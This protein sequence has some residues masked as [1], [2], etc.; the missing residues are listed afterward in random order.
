MKSLLNDWWQ[1]FK[2]APIAYIGLVLIVI[3]NIFVL[4]GCG[5]QESDSVTYGENTVIQR[6][7]IEAVWGQTIGAWYSS[8]PNVDSLK[9]DVRVLDSSGIIAVD[10]SH[11]VVHFVEPE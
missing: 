10:G 1:G 4:F 9:P 3:I 8:V 11:V 7:D 6:I 5:Q 2:M